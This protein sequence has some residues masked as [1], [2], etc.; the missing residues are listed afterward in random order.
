MHRSHVH[1]LDKMIELFNTKMAQLRDEFRVVSRK[2]SSRSFMNRNSNV[3]A[4]SC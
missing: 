4:P 3:T 1:N 2:S